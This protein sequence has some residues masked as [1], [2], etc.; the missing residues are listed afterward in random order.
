M[1]TDDGKYRFITKSQHLQSFSE[2]DLHKEQLD[3]VSSFSV[4]R[5]SPMAE[6]TP[7]NLATRKFQQAGK[8]GRTVQSF[9]PMSVERSRVR[10][11]L[12]IA[13]TTPAAIADAELVQA[14]T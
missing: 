3:E 7:L 4:I 8:P 11:P 13:R 14:R 9:S 1:V 5:Q 10:R 12:A 6:Q 2:A